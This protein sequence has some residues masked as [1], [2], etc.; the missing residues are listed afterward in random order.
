MEFVNR[1]YRKTTSYYSLYGT[2]AFSGITYLIRKLISEYTLDYS[3][4]EPLPVYGFH[5]SL[6][7]I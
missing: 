5:E 7:E 4:Q 3:D 1:I 2:E 6:K